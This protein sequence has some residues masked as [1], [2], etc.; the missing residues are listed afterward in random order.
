MEKTNVM[1]QTVAFAKREGHD[2]FFCTLK[3]QEFSVAIKR[4]PVSPGT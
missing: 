4:L 2:V 3:A 1:R